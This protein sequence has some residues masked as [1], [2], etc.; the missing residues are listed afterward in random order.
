MCG[1]V[2]WMLLCEHLLLFTSSNPSTT[3]LLMFKISKSHS[4]ALIIV[5]SL[6]NIAYLAHAN[7]TKAQRREQLL[8]PYSDEKD[9]DGGERAWVELGDRHPDFVYVL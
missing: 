4:S 2:F 6:F 5:I 3:A 1:R 9:A 8:A 7:R